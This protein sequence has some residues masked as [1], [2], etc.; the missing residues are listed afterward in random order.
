M[1]TPQ[2][3][4]ELA[5]TLPPRLLNFFRRFPPQ[6]A[7]SQNESSREINPSELG[8]IEEV[9]TSEPSDTTPTAPSNRHVLASHPIS[10]PTYNPFLPW[11]NPAT[12]RW[13]GAMYGLRKQ[14]D[15]CKL[16][17]TYGVEDLLPYS[18]KKLSEKLK[19]K[20]ELGLRIKGTGVGQR[21]KGHLWERTM[22]GR[23]EERKKAMIKMPEMVREWK[24]RGHGRGWKKWPK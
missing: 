14:A 15:I 7:V 21:V 19:R 24:Q 12:G 2:Q 9:A 8:A 3:K 13:R 11:K 18:R 17:R 5:K 1:A 6:Q 16:A 20:E 22:K 4:I 10:D 23:L